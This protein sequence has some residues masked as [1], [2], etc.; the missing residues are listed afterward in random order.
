VWDLRTYKELSCFFNVNHS[1]T[2]SVDI[3]QKSVLCLAHGHMVTF[4][5][6][7]FQQGFNKNK[8]YMVHEM[9]R[10]RIETIRFRPFEDFCGVGHSHGISSIV[11]PGSGEPNL[12]S[13]KHNLNP[14]ANTK[15]RRETEVLSLLDK[16]SPDTITLHGGSV[17]GSITIPYQYEL[18]QKRQ[19]M[20]EANARSDI[21]KKKKPKKEK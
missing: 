13:L 18:D 15:Q 1:P 3:S 20:E 21:T 7:P 2:Y 6:K 16:L 11:I 8:P 5:D 12:D 4:Y 19:V 10:K 9:G 14:F 17:V